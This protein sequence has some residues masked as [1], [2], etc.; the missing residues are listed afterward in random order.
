MQIYRL[1]GKC[2]KR[3]CTICMSRY[4]Q[5]LRRP[6]DQANPALPETHRSSHHR[7]VTR[8][9]SGSLHQLTRRN[10][11]SASLGRPPQSTRAGS[12]PEEAQPSTTTYAA[13]AQYAAGPSSPPTATRSGT[14][15]VYNPFPFQWPPAPLAD[16]SAKLP[17]LAGQAQ[18]YQQS[19]PP[20]HNPA[21]FQWP[22][23][24]VAQTS[25]GPPPPAAHAYN[26]SY[27]PSYHPPFPPHHPNNFSLQTSTGHQSARP[28]MT[29]T[30][31]V[32]TLPSYSLQT[33]NQYSLSTAI[34]M[35]I[36]SNAVAMEPPPV[37][38]N[39]RA[40]ILAGM[41]VDLSS[42]LSLLP[43]AQSDRQI[44]CGTSQSL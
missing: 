40:Q 24:P 26:P 20:G 32:H 7:R 1:Q 29:V 25:A 8:T 11:P 12:L 30:D 39:I 18:P 3:S 2:S 10:K 31:P 42:L 33:K 17:T 9:R 36:P 27:H 14:P 19:H 16:A 28:P 21:H 34:Q 13:A 23:A 43:A 4:K 5:R 37:S 6:T 38:Q 22:T 41:D 44:D 15:A 35:P